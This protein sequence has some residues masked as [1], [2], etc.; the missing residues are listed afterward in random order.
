MKAGNNLTLASSGTIHFEAAS[1]IYIES[2]EKRSGN[3]A[4]QSSQGEGRTDETLRQSQLIAKGNLVI[5]AADGIVAEVPEI[6]Q[7]T[8][9]QTIDAM[10]AADPDLAWL[11]EMEWILGCHGEP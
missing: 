3:F 2:H 9:S 5:Q 4:W 7:Q 11:K 6:N 1:D 8:V 10:V